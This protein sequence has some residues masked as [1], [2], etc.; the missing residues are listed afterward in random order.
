MYFPYG[1]KETDYL[2]KKDKKLA[3]VIERMGHLRRRTEDDLF[4]SVVHHIVGQQI[5]GA[6]Q[7]SIWRKM[8]AAGIISPARLA[9]C[10]PEDLRPFGVS[11]RKAQY[12]CDFAR[13][14]RD[15][16]FDL[17][18]LYDLSDEEVIARLTDI[19]GVGVWT[20]EMLLLFCLKRPNVLSFGDL[21]V[22][23]GLCAVY[24][25]KEISKK[26][27]EK[28]RRRFS[29]YGSV[30]AFYL[31]AAGAEKAAQTASKGGNIYVL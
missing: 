12:I 21:G 28:Y 5:S 1:K 4:A 10:A 8:Q 29:P 7:Q 17:N 19:K 2:K 16:S 30:A 23:R 31:W 26:L 20:A 9:A 14:V 18:G 13:R 3:R 6:A 24:G 15:G 11:L 22:R 27:F 25:H